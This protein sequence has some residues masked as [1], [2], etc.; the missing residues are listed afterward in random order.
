M[1]VYDEELPADKQSFIGLMT[2]DVAKKRQIHIHTNF[3]LIELDLRQTKTDK[4][5]ENKKVK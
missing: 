4:T 5:L 2:A 1:T 3:S